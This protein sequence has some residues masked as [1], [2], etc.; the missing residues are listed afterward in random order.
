MMPF[1]KTLA[2]SVAFIG[3]ATL[4]GCAY[5]GE[6]MVQG[7]NSAAVYFEAFPET[8]QVILDGVVVGPVSDFDGANQTL[9]VVPGSHV[10]Q[11]TDGS[12]VLYDK[13]IYVARD[14]ALKI[15]R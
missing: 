12:A 10:I 8:S 7:G 3:L 14:S 6:S 15:V 5:P 1:Q 13:K 4:G 9:G 11:I 2:I